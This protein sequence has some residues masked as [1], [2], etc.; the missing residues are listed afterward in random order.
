MEPINSSVNGSVNQSK[1]PGVSTKPVHKDDLKTSLGGNL[2]NNSQYPQQPVQNMGVIPEECV[3][4]FNTMQQMFASKMHQT[5]TQ[6]NNVAISQHPNVNQSKITVN[7]NEPNTMQNLFM[8]QNINQ[9]DENINVSSNQVNVSEYPI[10]VS[11]QPIN[12]SQQPINVTQYPVNVTQYPVNQSQVPNENI[13]MSQ[14][15][16][17]NQSSIPQQNLGQTQLNMTKKPQ[18]QVFQEVGNVNPNQSV[19]KSNVQGLNQ[20]QQPVDE[21]CQV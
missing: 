2:M 3:N 8:T 13:K 4:D 20:S 14:N 11:Q 7:E 21:N 17:I 5:M 15:S 6:G 10:N 12:V 16:Q 18:N 9:I 1:I 19:M